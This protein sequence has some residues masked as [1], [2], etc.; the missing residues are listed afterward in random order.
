MKI[1]NVVLWVIAGIIMFLSLY[2][3]CAI[4]D[5]I[6]GC[7]CRVHAKPYEVVYARAQ[8]DII[9]DIDKNLELVLIELQEIKRGA[10]FS[11][12]PPKC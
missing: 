12:A 7:S 1:L 11:S 5:R 10:R 6:L 8:R 4:F 9:T 3:F 2:A